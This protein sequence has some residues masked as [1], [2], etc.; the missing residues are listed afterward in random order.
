MP[1]KKYRIKLQIEERRHL[2]SIIR[3]QKVAASKRS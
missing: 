3:K 2:E 1:P